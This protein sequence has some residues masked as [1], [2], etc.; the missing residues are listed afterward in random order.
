MT[1]AINVI[2]EKTAGMKHTQRD[3]MWLGGL[4]P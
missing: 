1:I 2:F 4:I 3:T